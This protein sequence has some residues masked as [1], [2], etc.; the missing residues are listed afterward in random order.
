MITSTIEIAAPPAKVRDILLNFSAYPEWHTE[1]LK[2]IQVKDSNKTPQTL[3]S[4]D[5]IEVN[6]ENFKFVAEV[7]ENS[8][9][10]FSWQ[11]PPVFTIAGLHKF[12]MEPANDGASTVFTQTEDLKGLLSF[13]MSPSLLGK[14]M[15]AHF[16]IFHR[17]LKA[18]AE[19]A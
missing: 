3:S 1:W 15:A 13:I 2:E 6:I 9:N 8:E 11:G 4:G 12:H 19:Q 14:K 17:D 7:Q 16:D 18:R 5:R 10:L